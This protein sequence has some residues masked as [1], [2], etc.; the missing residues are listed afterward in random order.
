MREIKELQEEVDKFKRIEDVIEERKSN[1][2]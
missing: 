1:F 2:L